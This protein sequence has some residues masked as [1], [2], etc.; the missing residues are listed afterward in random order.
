MLIELLTD[1]MKIADLA[2]VISTWLVPG[3]LCEWQWSVFI[4]W[5]DQQSGKQL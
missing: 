3:P 4:S 2:L 1:Q 5:T